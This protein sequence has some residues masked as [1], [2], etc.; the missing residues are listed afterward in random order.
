[1][2]FTDVQ[3][4]QGQQAGRGVGFAGPDPATAAH[5]RE[6]I[7]AIHA[8]NTAN[9]T[10]PNSELRFAVEPD[11]GQVLIRLVDTVT[12][13]VIEQLPPEALLRMAEAL[14]ALQDGGNAK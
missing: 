13:E 7:S 9:A 12:N 5:R 6:I 2:T 14:R 1:M 10:A 11:T 3:A 8:V 4:V